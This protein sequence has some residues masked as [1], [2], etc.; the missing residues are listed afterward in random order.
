M[1]IAFKCPG[2]PTTLK[3]PDELAGRK[4]KCPKCG[5]G[6]LVPGGAAAPA[7]P[8]PAAA[9]AAA[10]KPRA[11]E[12]ELLEEE[13]LEELPPQAITND[14]PPPGRRRKAEVVDEPLEVL[15]DEPDDRPRKKKKKKGGMLLPMLL[16][17]GGVLG[18]LCAGLV[19]GGLMWWF[20]FFGGINEELKYMPDGCQVVAEVHVDQLLNSDAFAQVKKEFPD[21]QKTIDQGNSQA[22]GIAS[23]DLDQIVMGF[24]DGE[25]VIVVRSKKSIKVD[26]IKNDMKKSDPKGEI[27]ETKVGRFTMYETK[28]SN[29]FVPAQGFSL[30]DDR[31]VVLAK[32]DTLK[33]ILTR[34]KAPDFSEGLKAAMA[35]TDF[36][37]S[38]AAAGSV[39]DWKKGKSGGGS[40]IGNVG[41]LDASYA[42]KVDGFAI[43]V[44]VRSDIDVSFTALCADAKTADDVKKLID[45]GLVKAKNEK[46]VPSG[47][48]DMLDVQV[49][50]SG[51]NL[52]ASKTIKVAPIIKAYKD[53]MGKFK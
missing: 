4:G 53:Q 15:D 18:L 48:A 9:R 47:F 33:A 22:G 1:T 11:P 45:A 35:Q 42:D 5:T 8:P 31:R 14:K 39:K 10:A 32:P 34:D 40:P 12:P 26:D 50:V 29:Q 44:N 38:F 46:S 3:V 41:G 49:N 51:S 36:N 19:T 7:P 20:G 24:K 52:T 2:C 25:Q 21:I 6:F 17:G 30:V 13:P 23:S 43:K 28:S 37:A 27:K 16:I